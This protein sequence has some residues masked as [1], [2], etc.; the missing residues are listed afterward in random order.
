MLKASP[1][2]ERLPKRSDMSN[3]DSLPSIET[4]TPCGKLR[5]EILELISFLLTS[6]A[7]VRQIYCRI[8]YNSM[9]NSSELHKGTHDGELSAT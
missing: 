5:V 1:T 3:R 9:T 7:M 4:L 2:F 6:V 8:E